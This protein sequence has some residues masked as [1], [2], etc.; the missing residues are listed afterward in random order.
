MIDECPV[1]EDVCCGERKV[2][3]PLFDIK[4]ESP[5]D[6]EMLFQNS[7]LA[8]LN[9]NNK[10]EEAYFG[11]NNPWK[12]ESTAFFGRI[13]PLYYDLQSKDKNRREKKGIERKILNEC[14]QFEKIIEKEFNVE[15]AYVALNFDWNACAVAWAFDKNLVKLNEKDEKVINEEYK[16]SLEDIIE[17]SSGF[18]FKDKSKKII[19]MTFGLAFFNDVN[20]TD[21]ICAAILTHEVGHSFDHMLTDLNTRTAQLVITSSIKSIYKLFNPFLTVF[22]LGISWILGILRNADVKYDK[23]HEEEVGKDIILLANN[24]GNDATEIQNE[25]GDRWYDDRKEMIKQKQH[26]TKIVVK[27][28]KDIIPEKNN[29]FTTMRKFF[30]GTICGIILTC[31]YTLY[32]FFYLISIPRH[33]LLAQHRNYLRGHKRY[34]QFADTFAA[35]YGFARENALLAKIDAINGK[36]D[37]ATLNWLNYVPVL[38]VILNAS[39]YLKL[40][41]VHTIDEHPS[42][43]ARI[44]EAYKV[45]K[46]ELANN[47]EL[48]SEMK[49]E[50][51]QQIDDIQKMFDEFV[52]A[53]GPRNF[54]YRLWAKLTRMSMD[55]TKTDI[56]ANVLS[57]MQQ[58]HDEQALQKDEKI[59]EKVTISKRAIK[60]N[61][62]SIINSS[63]GMVG[64]IT[65]LFKK[66]IEA[67]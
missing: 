41:L 7:S 2:P 21:T 19:I 22:S 9:P 24:P 40:S 64:R 66:E 34:E 67:L 58:L 62:L 50:L 14:T 42:D 30:Y 36:I 23:K 51:E 46:W 63:T 59:N 49:K 5:V 4:Y 6:Y 53:S 13:R 48:T 33:I 17:T 45:C 16:L 26:E 8:F 60:N 37:L 10:G 27:D 12:L 29:F 28:I 18:K 1:A 15:R 31:K 11:E 38:N 47:K 61:A 52:Y 44:V 43:K 25:A 65:K 57:V 3:I 20:I 55:N 54:V 35:S 32:P 39:H 56:E